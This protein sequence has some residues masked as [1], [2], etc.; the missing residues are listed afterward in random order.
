VLLNNLEETY[1]QTQH[2]IELGH[3]DI[4][5]FSHG[6]GVHLS[7]RFQGFKRAL[8]EA[9]LPLREEWMWAEFGYEDAGIEHAKKFMALKE[10]PTGVCIVN[11]N[12]AA[13]FIH[14]IMRGGLQVPKD[15]SV[16]GCDDTAAAR[17]ALVPLTTMHRPIDEL[18]RTLVDL[19]C[20]RLDGSLQGPP[21]IRELSSKLIVRSSTASP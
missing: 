21:V 4:G 9:D 6:L 13:A 17:A 3:R 16:I 11:D 8:A 18:S 12:A 15:V 5:F 20:Q 2:L 1:L 14:A 19:L 7:S 10:R